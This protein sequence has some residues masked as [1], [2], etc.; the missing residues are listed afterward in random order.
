MHGVAGGSER[1]VLILALHAG[2]GRRSIRAI[3]ELE[4]CCMQRPVLP[5]A[6][7]LVNFVAQANGGRFEPFDFFFDFA[8]ASIVVFKAH[9]FVT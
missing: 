6:Q 3:I 1:L 8:T 5:V 9:G 7:M 4:S 2:D